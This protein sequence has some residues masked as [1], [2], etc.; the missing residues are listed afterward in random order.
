MSKKIIE[1]SEE[2]EFIN[3]IEK[4]DFTILNTNDKNNLEKILKKA[5]LNTINKLT[6][7]KP[8]NIRLCEA[9]ISRLKS[10]SLNK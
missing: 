9:D 1:T 7:K 4:G 5:S 2:L 6:R 8:I 10:I 3:S